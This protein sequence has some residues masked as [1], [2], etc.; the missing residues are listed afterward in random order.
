MKWIDI[1]KKAEEIENHYVMIEPETEGT[2]GLAVKLTGDPE[3][4]IMYVVRDRNGDIIIKGKKH[5]I[6]K[7]ISI[8]VDN[9]EKLKTEV[10]NLIS[11]RI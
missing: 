9:W 3:I 1:L 8:N 4:K 2:Y 5:S 6:Q 7:S 11:L 10:D